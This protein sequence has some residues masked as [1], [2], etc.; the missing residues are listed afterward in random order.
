MIIYFVKDEFSFNK[1]NIF[2]KTCDQKAEMDRL[3]SL[4]VSLFTSGAGR[5][6]FCRTKLVSLLF[7][8][9]PVQLL[10]QDPNHVSPRRR[11]NV[12]LKRDLVVF[13]SVF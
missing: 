2:Y 1:T 6:C 10:V 3:R 9:D 13:C 8:A 7:V 12:E 5:F 4:H 11:H